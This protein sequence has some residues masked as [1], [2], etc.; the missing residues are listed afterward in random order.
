MPRSGGV[1]VR[2]TAVPYC[3]WANR[4]QPPMRVWLPGR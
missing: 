3:G 4:R 2:L 1:S